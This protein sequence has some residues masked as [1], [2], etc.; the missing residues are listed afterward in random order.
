MA[1]RRRRRGRHRGRRRLRAA[2][3]GDVSTS[4]SRPT[5]RGHGAGHRAARRGA[6]PSHGTEL[7][8]W[9]HGNHPAAARLAARHGCERVAR[10]LGDAPRRPRS[11]CPR[12]ERARRRD[13]PGLPR[14]DADEWSRVNAA[15]FAH[16]PEQGA[17]DAANLAERMAEPW[18]DPAGLLVADGRLGAAR[19]PLDQAAR[20][21]PRR[22]VRRRR[23][24]RPRRAAGSARLLTLAGLHHLAGL[25]VRR[26]AA[27]RRVRQ[28]PRRRDVYSGLGLHARR[29]GHPR[30][31]PPPLTG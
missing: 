24:R 26:G 2:P 15:A 10:P 11:R 17:M 14:P 22:G 18:F 1:L 28:R 5:A 13:D 30:A 16:H 27:L 29:R 12:S 9:S 4:S 31:V 7:T 20:R 19:L 6:R 3:C 23:R 21:P 25:G 8:A